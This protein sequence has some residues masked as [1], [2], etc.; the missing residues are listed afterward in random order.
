MRYL[1]KGPKE[2]GY[3]GCREFALSGSYWVESMFAIVL[4]SF[5]QH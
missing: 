2:A 5:L 1:L 4:G 3:G